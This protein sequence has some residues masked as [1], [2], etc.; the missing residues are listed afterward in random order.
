MNV[1]VMVM[2]EMEERKEKREE[3]RGVSW[4]GR[5]INDWICSVARGKRK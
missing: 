1:G 2:E 3:R 4:R 5:R